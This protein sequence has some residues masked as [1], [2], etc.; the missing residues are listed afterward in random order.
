MVL[1]AVEGADLIAFVVDARE[2]ATALDQEIAR[3]LRKTN[4]PVVLV[5][6]KVD[7]RGQEPALADLYRLGFGEPL[8]VSGEHGRGVAEMLEGL[9]ERAPAPTAPPG[10]QRPGP[11][12]GIGPPNVRQSSLANAMPRP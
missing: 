6:S 8:G 12:A 5:A 7:D 10:G 4:K 1:A 3:L 9:R 11:I 2:G